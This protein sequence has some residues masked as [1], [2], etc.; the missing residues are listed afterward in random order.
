MG[1]PHDTFQHDVAGALKGPLVLCEQDGA[2]ETGDGVLVAEDADDLGVPLALAVEPLDGL[3]RGAWRNAAAE[4]SCIG[5]G[6]LLHERT[7]V[8][9][10]TVTAAS[11]TAIGGTTG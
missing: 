8:Q 1:R 11:Y 10:S 7:Q 5:V 6:C 9:E 3:V 4:I 2:D